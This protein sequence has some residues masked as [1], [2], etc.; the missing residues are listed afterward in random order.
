[1]ENGLKYNLQ[2]CTSGAQ[3]GALVNADWVK[4]HLEGADDQ[5]GQAT[6]RAS[7]MCL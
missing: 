4:L 2:S 1:V 3:A 5:A 6:A 7:L